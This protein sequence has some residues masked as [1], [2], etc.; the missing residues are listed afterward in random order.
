M[1]CVK[2]RIW[3]QNKWDKVVNLVGGGSVTNGATPSSFKYILYLN[4]FSCTDAVTSRWL[5]WGI[6]LPL[7]E[8]WPPLWHRVVRFSSIF[9]DFLGLRVLTVWNCFC[10]CVFDPFLGCDQQGR[11]RGKVAPVVRSSRIRPWSG[12]GHGQLLD[13][14]LHPPAAAWRMEAG[15]GRASFYTLVI[16]FRI[17]KNYICLFLYNYARNHQILRL[18]TKS[19]QY[20]EKSRGYPGEYCPWSQ[21]YGCS[22]QCGRPV[23]ARCSMELG[24]NPLINGLILHT[25]KLNILL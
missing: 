4:L 16:P 20:V 11:Q 14:L 2:F 5:S 12:H 24:W 22:R 3:E 13:G 18:R 25:F 6:G 1:W 23:R 8:P 9:S 21:F 19:I 15:G 7:Q 10:N 17:S